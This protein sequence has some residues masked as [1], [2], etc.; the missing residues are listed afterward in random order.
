MYVYN[1]RASKASEALSAVNNR[2]P[3][4]RYVL[5]CALFST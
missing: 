5:E 3:R 2:I 4:E 1:W